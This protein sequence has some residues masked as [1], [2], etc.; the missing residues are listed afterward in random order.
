MDDTYRGVIPVGHIHIRDSVLEEGNIFGV[1]EKK[2]AW[3]KDLNLSKKAEYIFFA[4]CGY[5]LMKYAGG[6]MGAIKTAEKMGMGM[7]R[8][9]GVS[10]VF[11]KV[12]IDVT[13]IA[14]K[15]TSAG[16]EDP[17]TRVLISAVNVLRKLGVDLGYLYEDE[18]CCGSPL[19]YAGFLDEYAEN[20]LKNYELFKSLE[21]KKIISI[22]PACTSSLENLYPKIISGYDIEVRHFLEVVAEKL[23]GSEIRPKLKER[24]VVTYHDPCQLS[25]YLYLTKEPREII[26]RIEGLELR[27]PDPMQ[28]GKWSTCCGGGGGMEVCF[29]DL[30]D[31]LALKRV[32]ELLATGAD[33]IV[34]S[35]PACE[36]QL[37]KGVSKVKAD[38]KVMDLAE[39]VDE[40]LG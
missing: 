35:C 24:R 19:Y 40:A 14:G 11:S 10:K 1:A 4:G 38:V 15:V 29:P 9:I 16:R 26:S 31:R 32:E 5:Q 2:S 33:T 22:I 36:L 28:R 21:V 12:G 6:L 25:R 17:Y 13:G 8:V 3:A 39:L 18:P 27:E 23:K 37:I 7:G 34:T 20:A 30:C